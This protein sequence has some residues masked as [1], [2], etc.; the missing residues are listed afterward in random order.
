MLAQSAYERLWVST[1]RSVRCT[2]TYK[3]ICITHTM[4]TEILNLF[5]RRFLRA[6]LSIIWT[7]P[8]IGLRCASCTYVMIDRIYNSTHLAAR[9]MNNGRE[10]LIYIKFRHIVNSCSND[11]LA[12]VTIIIVVEDIRLRCFL[13]IFSLNRSSTRT[14]K[15]LIFFPC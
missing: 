5:S 9:S 4:Q 6:S 14:S 7:A 1:Y 15:K 3:V 10:T 11:I 13:K 12:M 2:R 8:V